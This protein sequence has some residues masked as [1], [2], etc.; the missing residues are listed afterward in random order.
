MAARAAGVRARPARRL[1][2]PCLSDILP[3][4]ILASKYLKMLKE[5]R[6]EEDSDA[7]AGS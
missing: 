4:K 2:K 7:E 3:K 1:T 5:R 6:E